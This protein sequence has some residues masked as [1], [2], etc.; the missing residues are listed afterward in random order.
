[1]GKENQRCVC[2]PVSHL[3]SRFKAGDET[4][5][6]YGCDN[7]HCRA[8]TKLLAAGVSGERNEGRGR[9]ITP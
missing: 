4:S 6:I 7:N 9:P 3:Q 2:V 8:E 1:M 5:V